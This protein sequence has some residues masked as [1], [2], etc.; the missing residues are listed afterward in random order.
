MAGHNKW[1]QIKRQKGVVD[2]QK[3][4]AFSKLAKIISLAARKGDNPEM[5]AE[6][7]AATDK[8]RAENMPSD[9]I[10]RAIKKGGGGAEGGNLESIR[11]EAYGPGGAA[12]IIDAITDN[13][14][15]TVAEIKHILSQNK[16]RLA[17]HG[18][19]VWMFDLGGAKPKAKTLIELNEQDKKLVDGLVKSLTERDD[20]QEARTNIK[21]L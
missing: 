13:K 10:E 14:N 15:R 2:A 9:N 17:E 1:T 11:Y 19:V 18:A 7:R 8:A 21:N 5:N 4:K 6:L 20:V 16:A 3:S 12:I